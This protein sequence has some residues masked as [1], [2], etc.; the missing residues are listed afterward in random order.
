MGRQH[1]E[2]AAPLIA[3]YLAWIEKNTGIDRDELGR[4]ARAFEPFIDAIN[5]LLLDEVRGLA[6]GAAIA[7]DHAL[8]CQARGEAARAPLP[9]GCT[10]FAL[11]GAATHR[12]RTLAG[13][14]QDLPPEFSDLGIVLHLKP[15]DG[16]PR[17]DGLPR[18]L[19]GFI[20]KAESANL[21]KLLSAL[22]QPPA[23][24]YS[25]LELFLNPA[26]IPLRHLAGQEGG[27]LSRV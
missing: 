17:A 27:S 8:L 18:H 9:E 10:A 19:L 14:N 6:E 16:R 1:G 3:G 15:D 25:H 12:G 24:L 13:Q 21:S 4:R 11:T 2:Q 26:P 5:P 22:A 7:Y 23:A 20:F